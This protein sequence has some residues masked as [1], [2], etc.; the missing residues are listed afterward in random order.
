M[1]QFELLLKKRTKISQKLPENLKEKLDEFKRFIIRLK[2][3]YNFDLDSIFNIDE[4][5]MWFNIVG[6]ITVIN[7][8]DKI[9]HIRK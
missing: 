6:N 8:N 3:L 1:K 2:I 5:P 9:I 7:K 4:I